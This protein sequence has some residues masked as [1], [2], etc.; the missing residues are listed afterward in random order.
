[1][2]SGD[3]DDRLGPKGKLA[4][5]RQTSSKLDGYLAQMDSR[6]IDR[7][8]IPYGAGISKDGSTVYVD[9]RLDTILDGVDVIPA[10]AVHEQVEWALREYLGIGKNYAEDPTGHRIANRE[11]YERV[12]SLFPEMNPGEAWDEYDALI[13]PQVR[14]IE[15]EPLSDVPADL[16]TYPYEHDEKMMEKINAARSD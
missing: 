5:L 9:S 7:A 13:D 8:G 14:K 16:A 10:L 15:M 11:E 12:A 6:P 3:I 2:S 4:E 1:M